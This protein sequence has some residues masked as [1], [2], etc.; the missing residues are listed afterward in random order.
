MTTRAVQS[1]KGKK[2]K[3]RSGLGKVI[4]S[5]DLFGESITFNIDGE[6]E[7]KT[8]CGAFLSLILFLFFGAY[9]VLQVRVLLWREDTKHT[10]K[11][12]ENSLDKDKHFAIDEIGLDWVFMMVVENHQDSNNSPVTLEDVLDNYLEVEDED[13]EDKDKDDK[14]QSK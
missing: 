8:Y 10:K 12:E 9:F 2:V 1:K 6:A 13:D 11:E 5:F 4:K 3:N 14:N 7:Y